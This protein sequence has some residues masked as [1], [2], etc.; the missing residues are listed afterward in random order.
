MELAEFVSATPSAAFVY[1][2]PFKSESQGM[3]RC[4]VVCLLNQTNFETFAGGGQKSGL[5]KKFIGWPFNLHTGGDF[6]NSVDILA[7]CHKLLQNTGAVAF[8]ASPV[9]T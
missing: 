5:L 1:A 6:S 3:G 8:N 9:L 4:G 2:I 7:L